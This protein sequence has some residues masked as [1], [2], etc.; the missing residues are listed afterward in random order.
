ME[1]QTVRFFRLELPRKSNKKPKAPNPPQA[2][3]ICRAGGCATEGLREEEDESRF[4]GG[5]APGLCPWLKGGSALTP[6]AS[7][8]RS[9]PS[10]D[11]HFLF[12]SGQRAGKDSRTRINSTSTE[13][14]EKQGQPNLGSSAKSSLCPVTSTRRTTY[15]QLGFQ[16]DSPLPPGSCSE[17]EEQ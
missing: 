16:M 8:G 7:R 13:K 3:E 15:P 6:A 17:L 1:K 2:A 9:G 4:L 14:R 10:E 11:N 5:K 12:S